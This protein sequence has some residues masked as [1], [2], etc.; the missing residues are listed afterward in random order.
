MKLA[1]LYLKVFSAHPDA[2]NVSYTA[3]CLSG[4]GIFS[5]LWDVKE[6]ASGVNMP[7]LK[8]S[9]SKKEDSC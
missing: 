5:S 8:I 9:V 7:V 6:D 2:D 3:Q 4:E 1:Q